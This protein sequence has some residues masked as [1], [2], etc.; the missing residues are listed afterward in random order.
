MLEQDA[1]G[2]K[3]N[4]INIFFIENLFFLVVIKIRENL[5]LQ[6]DYSADFNKKSNDDT[7]KWKKFKQLKLQ[8]Q[9]NKRFLELNLKEDAL[10]D[11]LIT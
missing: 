3:K 10:K 7:W 1:S 9:S 2:A 8:R 11:K 5:L 6:N 4:G